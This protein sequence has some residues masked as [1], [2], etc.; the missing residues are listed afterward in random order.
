M[1]DIKKHLFAM[2]A[3]AFAALAPQAAAA[4]P[5]ID[6]VTGGFPI[7][8]LAST[9]AG[10][11]TTAAGSAVTCTTGGGSGQVTS[12]TTG[13]G[14]Y[15]LQGC[16]LTGLGA[17]CTS[18][19]QT[20]GTIKL[21]TMVMHLVYLDEKH[22]KPGVLATPP[23]SGVFAKFTCALFYNVEIKGNGVLG[24][25][26]TPKCGEAAS[27]STAL[28]QTVAAGT[29]KYTQ[30]EETG[31]VYDLTATI[32]GGAPETAGLSVGITGIAQREARLTCPDQI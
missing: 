9:G 30:V 11:L 29:Q 28:L 3:V 15:T 20:S 7:A 31:T 14:S 1:M 4:T 24:E 27:K 5:E 12:S 25:I 17:A 21:E 10:Q 2:T 23:A 22:T 26:T 6:P 19:G 18:P 13:E 16:Q 8:A 32:N